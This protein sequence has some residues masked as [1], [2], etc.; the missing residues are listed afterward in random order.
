ML[1]LLQSIVGAEFRCAI[2]C[3][4]PLLPQF[5]NLSTVV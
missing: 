1:S 3:E 4:L 2:D 5:V